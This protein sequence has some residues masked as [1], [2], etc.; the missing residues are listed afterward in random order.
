[1]AAMSSCSYDV[2][3]AMVV[4][5]FSWLPPK[6]LNRFKCVCK[7]WNSLVTSLTSN[8]AFVAKHLR[9]AHNNVLSPKS[10]LIL[11]EYWIPTPVFVPSDSHDDMYD[12]NLLL[13]NLSNDDGEKE[14]IHSSDEELRVDNPLGGGYLSGIECFQMMETAIFG[15]MFYHCDG[16]ICFAA[17]RKTMLWNPALHKSK[18]LP[19]PTH[20]Y[21][22]QVNRAVARTGFGYDPVDSD[23]KVLRMWFDDI[24]LI[25]IYSLNTD[26]YR[27]I[28]VGFDKRRDC[29]KVEHKMQVCH[30]GICYW[31]LSEG[32]NV[33]NMILSF[34]LH[35]EKFH[36]ILLPGPMKPCKTLEVWNDSVAYISSSGCRGGT[37]PIEMWV[38]ECCSR[39]V[40]DSS[41]WIKYLSIVPQAGVL[42]PL[43]F[44]ESDELLLGG[45]NDEFFVSYNLRTQKFRKLVIHRANRMLYLGSY[46]ES[47]VSVNRRG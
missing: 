39:G 15:A 10:L 14:E 18:L 16:I 7:S 5:I 31:F 13:L 34:D 2:P 38:M 23:Y 12:L 41:S 47:L 25:E 33:T 6:S 17:P 4:E 21:H 24:E 20:A 29:N 1:M 26:T 43:T 36:F 37:E 11:R 27:E 46:V 9:N 8:P 42:R 30:Q 19:L 28:K 40:S 22:F 3:E 32:E 35:A 44:W 45:T